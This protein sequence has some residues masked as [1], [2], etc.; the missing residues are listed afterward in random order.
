MKIRLFFLILKYI[1]SQ[2]YNI[3]IINYDDTST[4]LNLLFQGNSKISLFQYKNYESECD[5]S[6][7]LTEE[8]EN[9]LYLKLYTQNVKIGIQRNR[10]YV[11]NP[12][13]RIDYYLTGEITNNPI[14]IDSDFYFECSDG[15]QYY[16]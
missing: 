9:D 13:F 2:I 16:C 15:N 4:S 8:K 12:G 5:K 1:L 3:E 6:L 7:T 14:T 10:N 11:L